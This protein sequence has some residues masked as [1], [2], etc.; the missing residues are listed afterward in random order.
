[1]SQ[2]SY[3]ELK[4]DRRVY[5]PGDLVAGAVTVVSTKNKRFDYIKVTLE[6]KTELEVSARAVGL[7]DAFYS[8]PEA[9]QWISRPQEIARGGT[10]EIGKNVYSFELALAPTSSRNLVETLK[11][12]SIRTTYVVSVLVS[13]G[14]PSRVLSTECE[15]HVQVPTIPIPN[16]SIPPN[17]FKFPDLLVGEMQSIVKL[18]ST[19][20][21]HVVILPSKKYTIK[22]VELELVREESIFWGDEELVQDFYGVQNIQIVDGDLPSGSLVPFFFVV[23]RLLVSP[24]CRQGEFQVMYYMQVIVSVKEIDIILER[25]VPITFVR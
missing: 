13:R 23:P 19:I 9:I 15:L 24:T 5:L 2:H 4:L 25:K 18:P 11:G 21:G 12:S 1:M 14:F 8:P 6:G 3:V 22:Y 20:S 7:F 10:F 16:L 17:Q